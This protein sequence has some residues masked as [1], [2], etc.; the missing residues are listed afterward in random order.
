M[1]FHFISLLLIATTALARTA[2]RTERRTLIGDEFTYRTQ[3]D[4]FHNKQLSHID[5]NGDSSI[6][7]KG[8]LYDLQLR[9]SVGYL[10][11][12][13]EISIK[14]V[15]DNSNH[16]QPGNSHS[17]P[18]TTTTTITRIHKDPSP[19]A[20]QW[21]RQAGFFDRHVADSSSA[22][23]VSDI[24]DTNKPRQLLGRRGLLRGGSSTTIS[25][26]NDNSQHRE[27]FNSHGNRSKKITKVVSTIRDSTGAHGRYG[28]NDD[29]FD[30]RAEKK[31]EEMS[32]DYIQSHSRRALYKFDR[33]NKPQ[34]QSQGQEDIGSSSIEKRAMTTLTTTTTAVVA[35]EE[36]NVSK[37]KVDDIVRR[38]LV[39]IQ[40]ITQNTNTNT[41][42]HSTD[43]SSHG[44]NT[45]PVKVI[46]HDNN[47]KK[48]TKK[49]GFP[50]PPAHPASKKNKKPTVKFNRLKSHNKK[51]DQSK[52]SMHAT[53]S[54]NNK[55]RNKSRKASTL[56]PAER[57]AR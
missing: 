12:G 10:M 3:V 18:Y 32:K 20:E 27:A 23:A 22:A 48:K 15:N 8:L 28:G 17:N 7:Q 9:N 44:N 21:T 26:V 40:I 54:S 51:S 39:T 4:N 16:T 45:Y 6:R 34:P 57:Q 25:N 53:K 2:D 29:W 47:D 38:N 24:K 5:H 36:D 56:A 52:T 31:K 42:G 1:K 49:K 43:S 19:E 33:N 14:N 11:G 13:G 50:H 35:F 41:N 37:E 30:K 55:N 46:H